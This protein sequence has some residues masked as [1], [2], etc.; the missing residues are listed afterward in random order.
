[1]S[2]VQHQDFAHCY[3]PEIP[4]VMHRLKDY[5]EPVCFVR[6]STSM[7]FRNTARIPAEL[8]NQEYGY[9][10]FGPQ[11][12]DAAFADAQRLAGRRTQRELQLARILAIAFRGDVELAQLELEQFKSRYGDSMPAI[13]NVQIRIDECRTMQ[14]EGNARTSLAL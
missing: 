13:K 5:I 14:A 4:L 6:H 3:T 8:L 10:D 7:V 12:C 1:V 9:G 11:E 2:V